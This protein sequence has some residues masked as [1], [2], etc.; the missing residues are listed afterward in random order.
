MPSSGNVLEQSIYNQMDKRFSI[1]NKSSAF[2]LN[3]NLKIFISIRDPS[4]KT[5]GIRF[6]LIV[7]SGIRIRAYNIL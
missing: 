3:K 7:S 2:K 1:T 4:S 5:L 6:R